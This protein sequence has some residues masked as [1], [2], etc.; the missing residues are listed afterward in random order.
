MPQLIAT[1]RAVGGH[2]LWHLL[3]VAG[4]ALATFAGIKIREYWHDKTQPRVDTPT[5]EPSRTFTPAREA[6]V[7]LAACSAAASAIHASVCAEHFKE[8]VAFGVFFVIAATLQAAWALLVIQR[9][10]RRV[11][12][13]AAVGNTAVIMLWL[14]TRTTG[15]P[16]GPET[17]RPETIT[18]PDVLTTLAELAIVAGAIHLLDRRDTHT[19]VTALNTSRSQ[20]NAHESTTLIAPAPSG[21]NASA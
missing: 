15:L 10:T 13:A 19:P 9:P 16:I 6:V 14:L 17:W 12:I 21:S 2:P 5:D 7:L 8:A 4:A 3:I 11:L 1:V 20:P 18:T